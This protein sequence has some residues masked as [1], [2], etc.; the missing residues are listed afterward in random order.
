M[1][2]SDWEGSI[3]WSLKKINDVAIWRLM[4]KV[5]NKHRK[6]LSYSTKTAFQFKSFKFKSN[7][8]VL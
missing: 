2:I 8:S 4:I 6:L 7:I 5:H 3:F 1:G